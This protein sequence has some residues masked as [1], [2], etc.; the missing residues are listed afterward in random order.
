MK[1]K[2]EVENLVA[3]GSSGKRGSPLSSGNVFAYGKKI[4]PLTLWSTRTV[5]LQVRVLTIDHCCSV[6][7]FLCLCLCLKS[8][9]PQLE[10]IIG[11]Y[12]FF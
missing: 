8:V 10:P 6:H 5:I 12:P 2:P 9:C 3:K 7:T 1:K 4:S 11:I